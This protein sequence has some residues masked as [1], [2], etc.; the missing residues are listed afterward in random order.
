MS[1]VRCW[2]KSRGK[3]GYQLRLCS[4]RSAVLPGLLNPSTLTDEAGGGARPGHTVP[5]PRRE[6]NRAAQRCY[7]EVGGAIGPR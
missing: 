7:A 6:A 4:D 5:M 2:E 1:R 3:K